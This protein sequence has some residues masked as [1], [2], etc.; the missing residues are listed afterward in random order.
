MAHTGNWMS[1]MADTTNAPVRGAY[2]VSNHNQIQEWER[3]RIYRVGVTYYLKAKVNGK[4]LCTRVDTDQ[5]PVQAC[6]GEPQNWERFDVQVKSFDP[7]WPCQNAR[8]VS[9]LYDYWED[10]K[11]GEHKTISKNKYNA[12]DISGGGYGDPILAIES[13]KV[14]K[15]SSAG[16]M[17]NHVIIEHGNGLRSV[18][19]HMNKPA[20]VNVGDYV[21]RGQVIGY[22]GST[23]NSTGPHLHLDVH[24]AANPTKTINPWVTWYQGK[25]ELTINGCC[26][27]SNERYLGNDEARNLCEWLDKKCKKQKN[28]DYKFEINTDPEPNSASLRSQSKICIY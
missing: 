17:G 5:A 1:T 15:K 22:M 25:L 11:G 13:G 21:M 10:G 16:T 24:E 7:V 28:G 14:V 26:Y 2:D 3:F 4:W 18:Y 9:A 27:K 19:G 23:G 8:Y 12:I 20:C 6:A